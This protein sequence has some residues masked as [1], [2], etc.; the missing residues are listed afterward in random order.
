MKIY[1]MSGQQAAGWPSTNIAACMHCIRH[2]P[3]RLLPCTLSARRQ[4]QRPV[5]MF[6]SDTG[7]LCIILLNDETP[8]KRWP[9]MLAYVD[10]E[11]C[12]EHTCTANSYLQHHM[13]MHKGS[14]LRQIV[15]LITKHV[16]LEGTSYFAL[17]K[18][19]N[20]TSLGKENRRVT[21]FA[22]TFVCTFNVQHV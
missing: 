14:K 21:I 15:L 16:Q 5:Q 4:Y 9:H 2:S 20:D 3:S 1:T 6:R 17:C 22:Y 18:Q 13:D 10:S 12:V 7:S 8:T 19:T 11:D